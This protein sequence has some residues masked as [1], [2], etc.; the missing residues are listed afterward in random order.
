MPIWILNRKNEHE[1]EVEADEV[2]PREGSYIF[3]SGGVEI[4]FVPMNE[5]S[6]IRRKDSHKNSEGK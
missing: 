4:L 3:W 5:V 1:S 2:T 6:F